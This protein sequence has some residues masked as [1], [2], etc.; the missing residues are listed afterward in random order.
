MNL[1]RV[2]KFKRLKPKR[3]TRIVVFGNCQASAIARMLGNGLPSSG[4]QVEALSNNARTGGMKSEDEIITTL[5]QADILIF[6][7][8][9]ENYGR[10]S[11]EWIRR[12]V[13]HADLLITYPYMFNS[14]MYSFSHAP[15]A[16]DHDYGLIYGEEIIF[17][18]LKKQDLSS[19]L[20]N[21][22]QGR[23]DFRLEKR[24]QQCISGLREREGSTDI[25]LA[26]FIL[27]NYKS[28]KLFVTH[29]HPATKLLLE[30]CSQIKKASGLPLSLSWIDME[31]DNIGRLPE[32]NTPISPYDVEVHGYAFDFHENWFEKG[33]QLIELIGL[34]DQNTA[35]AGQGAG[36]TSKAVEK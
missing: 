8:L 32:P 16:R 26:D 22:E 35:T 21:Y 14:G 27:E 19:I 30:V 31:N 6:Q 18:L 28:E 10:L 20:K 13:T 25:K 2:F 29:N 7:P 12:N 36:A 5:K 11:A 3:T 15:K 4:Y 1:K 34:H 23:I 9:G 17:D 24:F 33:K